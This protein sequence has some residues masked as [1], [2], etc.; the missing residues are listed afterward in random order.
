M[1]NVIIYK[2][3]IRW[4]RRQKKHTQG[5]S[6]MYS[7]SWVRS[8]GHCHKHVLSIRYYSFWR[9]LSGDNWPYRS[10]DISVYTKVALYL[11]HYHCL[12]LSLLQF[13]PAFLFLGFRRLAGGVAA[14][15][16]AAVATK[17]AKRRI[18]TRPRRCDEDG[19][20]DYLSSISKVFSLASPAGVHKIQVNSTKR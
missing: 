18:W 12:L 7:K 9:L 10:I 11:I 6:L 8:W 13:P 16:A 19:I 20:V 14:A 4:R 1:R 15:I 5:G 17:E 3:K 2:Y